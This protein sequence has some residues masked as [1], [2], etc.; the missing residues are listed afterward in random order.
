MAFLTNPSG[1]GQS[2]SAYNVKSGSFLSD[3]NDLATQGLPEIAN[4]MVSATAGTVKVKFAND[5]TGSVYL[6]QGIVVPIA[7]K[8]IFAAGSSV[9]PLLMF[10]NGIGGNGGAVYQGNPTSSIDTPVTASAFSFA[11]NSGSINFATASWKADATSSLWTSGSI[12]GSDQITFGTALWQNS[13]LTATANVGYYVSASV[14]YY[15]SAS[16]FPSNP[17]MSLGVVGNTGSSGI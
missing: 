6:P 13:E 10:D 7:V 4:A 1:W 12:S 8:Q 14:W 11:Y 9:T 5:E 16:S 15:V 3:T 2:T 17:V